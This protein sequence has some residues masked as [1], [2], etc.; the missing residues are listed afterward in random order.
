MG[1]TR[2][3]T[4]P[5]ASSS[6]SIACGRGPAPWRGWGG[7]GGGGGGRGAPR[8]RRGVEGFAVTRGRRD[9]A[10]GRPA[11][12]GPAAVAPVTRDR[13]GRARPPPAPPPPPPRRALRAPPPRP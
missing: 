1:S 4:W 10:G 2:R 13:G 12:Q 3:S 9:A 7:A 11:L 5:A 6:V 8:R